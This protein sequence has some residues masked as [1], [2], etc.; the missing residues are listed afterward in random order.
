MAAASALNQQTNATPTIPQWMTDLV[1]NA[2]GKG[3]SSRGGGSSRAMA[4]LMIFSLCLLTFRSGSSSRAVSIR[5]PSLVSQEMT[6]EMQIAAAVARA[7]G[8][9]S[10]SSASSAARPSMHHQHVTTAKSCPKIT[11]S[12]PAI[13]PLFKS[14]DA[15]DKT[16]LKW[17]NGLCGG[18]Y[19]EMGGLD[20]VTY[21]NSYV[22]NKSP[23][24][25]TGVLV[26]GMFVLFVSWL[27]GW[28][29]TPSVVAM[30]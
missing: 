18:T 12:D 13:V 21:S 16:L 6:T 15:E 30:L 29:V 1:V 14:Q 22:F 23:L 3:L 10:S 5:D 24:N 20:G 19:I 7:M 9:S 26:E 27:V 4:I 2:V 8:S 11:L 25:W 17:F 28:L